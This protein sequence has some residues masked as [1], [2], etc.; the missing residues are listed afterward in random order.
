[1]VEDEGGEEEAAIPDDGT[2]LPHSLLNRHYTHHLG[3]CNLHN[4]HIHSCWE[5]SEAEMVVLELESGLEGFQTWGVNPMKS[6][7]EIYSSDKM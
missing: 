1:M 6:R 4:L 7:Y 2:N 3:G 5:D